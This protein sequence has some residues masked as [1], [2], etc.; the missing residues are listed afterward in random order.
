MLFKVVNFVKNKDSSVQ[1]IS[2]KTYDVRDPKY[3][4]TVIGNTFKMR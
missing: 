4:F 3:L 2:C 1:N